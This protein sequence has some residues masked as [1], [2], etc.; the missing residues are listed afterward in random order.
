MSEDELSQAC[1]KVGR[2]LY[3]FALVE[4]GINGCITDIL[5]LKGDAADV[6]AHSVDFFRKANLLRT[7]AM[8]TG[9]AADRTKITK[10]F[11][12]IAEQNNNRVM[13]AHSVFEPAEG[14]GV[15]FRRTVAKD[16]AVKKQDP[17][18][19]HKDFAASYNRL[20]EIC[21]QLKELRPTLVYTITEEGR[22]EILSRYSY[23]NTS[24]TG[25]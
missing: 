14:G 17:L 23:A 9:P 10:L 19:T 11:S 7:V 1:S 25:T 20:Q 8:N 3:E 12:A 16:G 24:W 6:V 18:W 5:Q 21:E 15:Q 13:L 22:T 4:D 2:F